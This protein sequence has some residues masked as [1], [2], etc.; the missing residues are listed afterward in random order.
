MKLVRISPQESERISDLSSRLGSIEFRTLMSDTGGTHRLMRPERLSHLASG[1]GRISQ[2]E[3]ERL[4]LIS[5]NSA[6]LQKLSQKDPKEKKRYRVRHAMRDWLVAGKEKG[7]T[8]SDKEREQRA[9]RALHFLGI[10]P[11]EGTYYVRK[12]KK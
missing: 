12:R 8:Q 3:L 6:L 2:A 4:E 1:R 5:A 10:D 11:S 7:E 9:V